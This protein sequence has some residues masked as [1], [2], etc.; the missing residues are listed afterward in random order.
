MPVCFNIDGD[1][2]SRLYVGARYS[3]GLKEGRGFALR[4][5]GAMSASC[6]NAWIFA[7]PWFPARE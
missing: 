5:A 1:D 6:L 2:R 4:S 3:P 7:E